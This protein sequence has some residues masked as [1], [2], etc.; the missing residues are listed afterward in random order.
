[1]E[2]W[3]KEVILVKENQR[4]L[5]IDARLRYQKDLKA[6]EDQNAYITSHAQEIYEME[7]E[8]IKT[9]NTTLLL[10]R[11]THQNEIEAKAFDSNKIAQQKYEDDVELIKASN[12]IKIK[13]VKADFDAKCL[14]T[15]MENARLSKEVQDE[16]DTMLEEVTH[17]FL[18]SRL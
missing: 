9:R 17:S 15:T 14:A 7:I 4:Q 16:F 3:E 2:K 12:E 11:E 18:H 10:E 13:N 1:M 5:D 8:K 6:I